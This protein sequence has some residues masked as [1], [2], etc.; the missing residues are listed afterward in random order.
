MSGNYRWN[1]VTWPDNS[2]KRLSHCEDG[3]DRTCP[4]QEPDMSGKSYWN[5]AADPDN[6]GQLE[7]LE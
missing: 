6:L 7:E 3:V 2:D 4:V 5:P 1:P